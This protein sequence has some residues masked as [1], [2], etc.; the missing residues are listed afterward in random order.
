MKSQNG[1]IYHLM[2]NY[3]KPYRYR[4]M[5][6]LIAMV[7]KVLIDMSFS[8][9]Y[10]L[11]VDEIIYY[12]NMEAFFQLVFVTLILVFAYIFSCV[13]ETGAFWNTQLRFVLDLR[14]GIMKSIYN[15]KAQFL[16]HMKSGDVLRSVNLDTPE[17]MNVIT[18]NFFETIST[19]AVLLF[20]IIVSF[21]ID[22]FLALAML[23]QVPFRSF[24]ALK[25][26]NTA[27][28]SSES[29]R[30]RQGELNSWILEIV[31]GARDIRFLSAQNNV[32]NLFSQY[33]NEIL[34]NL[35]KLM[36]VDNYV[37]C[38]GKIIVLTSDLCF[39]AVG[40]YLVYSNLISIGAFISMASLAVFSQ[41]QL[42]KLCEFY[43][44]L[45]SRQ[46]SLENVANYIHLDQES[47]SGKN[48]LLCTK[49]EIVISNLTFG[50]ASDKSIL[51]DFSFHIQPGE[52][53]AVVGKSG[54]GKS[55]F[56]KLLIQMYEPNCGEILIDGQNIRKCSHKSVRKQ[57]GYVQQDVFLFDGT[58]RYNLTLGDSSFD[59]ADIM[60]ACEYACVDDL[61]HSLPDGLDTV[62]SPN[63]VQLSGGQKQRLAIARIILRNPAIV[64]FDEVTS[65]LDSETEELMNLVWQKISKDKTSI[66]VTH[67]LAS[68]M[69]ADRVLVLKDGCIEAC[70]TP[71]QLYKS[72]ESF[73]AL[74]QL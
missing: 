6:L 63:E 51:K 59:D 72:N 38:I 34:I 50:Y 13:I 74:F 11:I 55:T 8:I 9:M 66:I 5:V 18:D 65:A 58:I 25:L 21:S 68:A 44:L 15:A 43:I 7:M 19:V 53:I 39:Y 47:N 23:I 73:Q 1:Q 40:V 69:Q 10:G 28:K 62:L 45:K 57:I 33:Y 3:A 22:R 56:V 36:Y 41:K 16:D 70:G 49:G 2:K 61:I 42:T 20:T 37:Q 31:R 30:M 17:Y 24:L 46:V 60:Q 4:F 14:V 67:R 26:G 32:L 48:E 64:I 52:Q 12:R 35:K 27:K 54:S 29:L 71:E